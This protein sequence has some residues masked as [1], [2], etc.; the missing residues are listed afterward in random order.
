[1]IQ[2]GLK[3]AQCHQKSYADITRREAE[4]EVK[5]WVFFKV[6]PMKEVMK[7]WKKRKLSPC[8]ICPFQIVRRIGNVSYEL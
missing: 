8:Y 3:T 2:E 5:V 6:S 1:M 4:F 7:F